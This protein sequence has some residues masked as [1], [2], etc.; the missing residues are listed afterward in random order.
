MLKDY[1][2]YPSMIRLQSGIIWPYGNSS[3]YSLFDAMHPLHVAA[4]QCNNSSFCLWYISPLWEFNDAMH[5]KYAFMGESNKWTFVSRQRFHSIETN[6]EQ[7][8]TIIQIV[9]SPSEVV[10]LTVYHSQLGIKTFDCFLSTTTGQGQLVITPSTMTCS[11][12]FLFV[13]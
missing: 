1:A 13:Q 9:G 2:V 7:T 3:N 6:V 12:T 4:S 8:Q 10:S 11:D 5:I